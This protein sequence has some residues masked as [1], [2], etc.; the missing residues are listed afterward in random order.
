MSLIVGASTYC[1]LFDNT[2][3]ATL[4]RIAA[5]G[6]KQVEIMACPPH[7]WVRDLDGKAR[8]A[9]RQKIESY[10]L[11]VFSTQP[12]LWP[13]LCLASTNPGIRG[14]AVRQMREN[15]QLLHDL[16]GKVLGTMPGTMMGKVAPSKEQALDLARE[17]IRACVEEAERLGITIAIENVP[18]GFV[19][20]GDDVVHFIEEIGS[21]A[22][23]ATIDVGNANVVEPPIVAL[24]RAKEHLALV[25]LVDNDGRFDKLPVGRGTID[26]GAIANKLREI[27]YTGPSMLEIV[28]PEC[29]DE[30]FRESK[31]ALEKLGWQA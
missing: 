29:S 24:E 22:L 18:R 15:I 16:G 13:E 5:M 27:G 7:I 4:E 17:S 19:E 3:E 26:F 31:A 6:F 2:L 28:M 11:Q 9:L 1:Y 10:G 30:D 12:G 20:T 14:E 21:P 25:H 8:K 23:G